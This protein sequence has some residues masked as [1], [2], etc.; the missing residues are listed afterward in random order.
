M[1]TNRMT[2]LEHSKRVNGGYEMKVNDP[3]MLENYLTMAAL[4]RL[5]T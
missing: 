5:G 1:Q 3:S 4:R 2:R